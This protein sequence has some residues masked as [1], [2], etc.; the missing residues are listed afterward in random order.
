MRS[1]S[2]RAL[3]GY[4]DRFAVVVQDAIASHPSLFTEFFGSTSTTFVDKSLVLKAFLSDARS[5]HLIL[6]LRR[7]GKS[8]TLSMVRYVNFLHQTSLELMTIAS[9]TF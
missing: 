6:R 7:A 8:F 1:T 3:R 4:N 9:G 5:H 2:C